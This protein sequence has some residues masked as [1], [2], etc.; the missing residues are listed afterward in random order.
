M[1]VFDRT[2]EAME[3][4]L[5]EALSGMLLDDVSGVIDFKSNQN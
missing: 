4:L 3:M 2:L 5:G 1:P